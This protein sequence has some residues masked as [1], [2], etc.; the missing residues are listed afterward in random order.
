ME[1]TATRPGNVVR[2]RVG[3]VL[4]ALAVVMAAILGLGAAKAS[5]ASSYRVLECNPGKGV[6]SAN[7]L[8]VAGNY[9]QSSWVFGEDCE[10]SS[11]SGSQ[12]GITF[13]ANYM[14]PNDQSAYAQ[15]Y[16]PAGTHFE[17][18]SVHVTMGARYPC[19]ADSCWY[20]AF[21]V[22][23]SFVPNWAWGQ[24]S[25][26]RSYSV[27]WDNCGNCVQ[28]WEAM[29]CQQ[30]CIH[31]ASSYNGDWNYDYVGMRDLDV[32]LV[33]PASPKLAISGSVFDGQIAH[34]QP[35]LQINAIDV[36]G[37]V[38]TASVDVNGAAVAAP[39]TGCP[40][41][42][43]GAPW[44]TAF[45]PC[46]NLASTIQLDTTKTPWQDG[47]N[48]LRVCVADVNT[49]PGAGN[50]V[51][52]QRTVYVDNSCPDSQGASG[53]ATG[54]SA[55]LENPRTGQ[56]SR[57]RAVRSTDGTALKG[58]LAGTGGSPVRAA[59]ACVYETVDEPAGIEQLVQVA[60]SSSSG[61]FGIQVPAGPSRSFRVAYRYN[62]NQI[63]SPSMYLDSSVLPAL[64]LTK[65]KL[66]NGKAV[67]FRGHLPGPGNGG[68]GVTM[69][70]R[71]GKKWRSFKQLTTDAN[72]E[73][74]GKY[75]F[76]QTRGRV[77]YVFRAL[78]KKQGGYPYSEGASPKRKVLVKG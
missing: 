12:K 3:R 37:G 10:H 2:G 66:K 44:A 36:G 72:G 30:A 19:S 71:V 58:Q 24:D 70:A 41:I 54:I 27:A 76:T 53:Q 48:A 11:D 28:V 47:S 34:G 20:S 18:G 63:E 15:F 25:I 65:S 16:A 75:R 46:G 38:R 29:S 67:G 23:N 31:D 74:R 49:G 64:E 52:D 5:A 7:D 32:T 14:A 50:T 8:S 6:T 61:T 55:G 43:A 39:A 69:Q 45:R 42:G 78:V 4:L 51:C 57:T 60:K 22:G 1:G 26:P 40:Y 13:H 9:D 33:D 62:N 17:T 35:T 59:S 56:L 68:R 77:V 21:Y 73:F